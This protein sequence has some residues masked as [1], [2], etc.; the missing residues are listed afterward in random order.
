M[1]Q[2]AIQHGKFIVGGNVIYIIAEIVSQLKQG[3]FNPSYFNTQ[4]TQFKRIKL[5]II[6]I[7]Y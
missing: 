3:A 1:A 5:S 6:T 4:A 2:F 7:P